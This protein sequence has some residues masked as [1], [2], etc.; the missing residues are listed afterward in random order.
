MSKMSIMQSKCLVNRESVGV[1]IIGLII[2]YLLCIGLG[3]G[4]SNTA[5]ASA[6]KDSPAQF[7]DAAS[8]E[9]LQDPGDVLREVAKGNICIG[10]IWEYRKAEEKYIN[11]QEEYEKKR[12]AV[13]EYMEDNKIEAGSEFREY[14]NENLDNIQEVRE[15]AAQKVDGGY[16]LDLRI[17]GITETI[18]PEE[19]LLVGADDAAPNALDVLEEA[20]E[21]GWINNHAVDGGMVTKVD[22]D[23]QG[24]FGGWD[25]WL[26]KV[27]GT[28]PAEGAGDYELKN[29]DYVVWYYGEMEP[30]THIPEIDLAPEP[31]VETGETLEV[32]VTS[33]YFCFETEEPQKEYIEDAV[34]EFTGDEYET[35]EN[36][37]AE[38]NMPEDAGEYYLQVHKDLE[39]PDEDMESTFPFIVRTGEIAFE[40]K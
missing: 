18:L 26:F 12:Q 27:N 10:D 35:D 8:G 6:G 17:E 15:K 21:E 25:G 14:V 22:D 29:D 32:T 34:V 20:E 24:Y 30:E 28:S 13:Y 4:F 5:S 1:G 31:P 7:F 36:G 40:V 23:E 9:K 33:E 38:I 2:F 19:S 11:V 37:T 39:H 16:V 3:T